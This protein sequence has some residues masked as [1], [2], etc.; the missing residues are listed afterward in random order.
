MVFF[1]FNQTGDHA[2]HIYQTQSY[3]TAP[4]LHKQAV[5]PWRAD[6]YQ[7]INLPAQLASSIFHVLW[8]FIFFTLPPAGM[9]RSDRM[10]ALQTMKG[11]K[12]FFCVMFLFQ[13]CH[14]HYSPGLFL[15]LLLKVMVT[16]QTL[17]STK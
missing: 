4:V 14:S 6:I 2:A 9:D 1:L 16:K 5:S 17:P 15:Y 8:S 10:R 12:S 11:S 3:C 7:C 13:H